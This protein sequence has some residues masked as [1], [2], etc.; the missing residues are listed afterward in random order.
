MSKVFTSKQFIDKLKWLANKVPNYYYSGKLWL[1][2]D[3]NKDKFR[4]DC[5]LSVKGILWGFSASS[6][7]GT[8]VYTINQDTIGNNFH[9]RTTPSKDLNDYKVMGSY[10]FDNH[11]DYSNAA[12]SDGICFVNVYGGGDWIIQEYHRMLWHG[13]STDKWVR[14]YGAGVWSS[15]QKIV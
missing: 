13:S 4:M 11:G 14:Q 1:T 8:D 5:V 9:K 3:K 10:Q 6:P 7:V 2:Y 12:S 15:W